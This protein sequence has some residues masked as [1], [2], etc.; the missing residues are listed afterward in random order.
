MSPADSLD[1]VDSGCNKTEM[2]GAVT[3][4]RANSIE[5]PRPINLPGEAKTFVRAYFEYKT[6][7]TVII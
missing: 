7:I 5:P 6:I 2:N 1:S 4:S 3:R